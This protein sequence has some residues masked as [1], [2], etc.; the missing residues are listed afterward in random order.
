MNVAMWSLVTHQLEN[1]RALAEIDK[2]R[3]RL[4]S[5]R[6]AVSTAYYALFQ[7]LCELC[8]AELVGW[9]KP[10]SS[11]TPIFRSVE[12]VHALFEYYCCIFVLN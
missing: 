6:R 2:R 5:L 11:F 10:W 4:A 9:D 1:A 12:H 8:A 7:A 3:P